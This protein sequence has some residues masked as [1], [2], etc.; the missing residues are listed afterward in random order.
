MIKKLIAPIIISIVLLAIIG[1]YLFGIFSFANQL[2]TFVFLIILGVL[3]L[4]LFGIIYNLVERVKEL[5]RGDEDD[6]SKY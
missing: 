3:L 1:M 5:K 2:P 4:F 6:I